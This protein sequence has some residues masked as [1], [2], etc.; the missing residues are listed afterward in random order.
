MSLRRKLSLEGIAHSNADSATH[1][2][3]V[4]Q[5]RQQR[6]VEWI[7]EV[8]S[9]DNP[10]AEFRLQ[11][12]DLSIGKGLY[13]VGSGESEKQVA[14]PDF[15]RHLAA[16][17]WERRWNYAPMRRG[18]KVC[19]VRRQRKSPA[20]GEI[21]TNLS[22]WEMNFLNGELARWEKAGIPSDQRKDMLFS[23]LSSL[24][25]EVVNEF[26]AATRF[27]VPGSYAHLDSNKVHFGIINTRVTGKN[28]F[29][30]GSDRY[31]R[32]IG[33]WSVSMARIAGLGAA[34]PADNRLRQNLERFGE[35]HGSGVE[36]LD[37][38]LHRVMDL[39][40]DELVAGMDADAGK[41]YEAAKQ[42][43]RDWKV[44]ARRESAMRSPGSQRIAWEVLR[45][46]TPLFPPQVRAAIGIART[47]LQAFQVVTAAIDAMSPPPPPPQKSKTL[48]IDKV[49]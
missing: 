35:R 30:E 27:E 25:T 12:G 1:A 31:L 48:E 39:K 21:V 15:E 45:T 16:I 28:E 42:Y 22:P 32:T 37:M 24:R 43:Y 46:V 33:P 4:R 3:H 47:A 49:L 29:V 5:R 40:F 38:R 41:R 9:G 14:G 10:A 34:D 6:E 11:A 36:P 18:D 44:K 19:T 26:V 17:N 8:I 20:C 13:F 2:R 7:P 23:F